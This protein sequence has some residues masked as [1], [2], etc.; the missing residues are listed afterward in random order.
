MFQ[1]T[2]ACDYLEYKLSLRF[3][4]RDSAIACLPA[5]ED[6]LLLGVQTRG[7]FAI[8]F[9]SHDPP[10]IRQSGL[11]KLGRGEDLPRSV[12]GGL[13]KGGSAGPEARLTTASVTFASSSKLRGKVD[14][15]RGEDSY[16]GGG[17]LHF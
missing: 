4:S 12:K 13:A 5:L 1:L 2:G 10:A 14:I 8:G 6:A 16:Q 17:A 7:H 11:I 3:S 9:E 15:P